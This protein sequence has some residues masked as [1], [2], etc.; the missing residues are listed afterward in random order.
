M[1]M[2]FKDTCVICQ[3]DKLSF[4]KK[5][6]IFSFASSES[7]CC[8]NCG[9]VFVEDELKWRLVEMKDRLNPIWQEFRLK[10]FYVREWVNLGQAFCGHAAMS[11]FQDIPQDQK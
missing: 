3:E 4:R 10:S 7:Y 8:E 5:K 6:A 11:S 2:L 1:Q 9:A